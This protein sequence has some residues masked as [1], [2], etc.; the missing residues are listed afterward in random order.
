MK[1]QILACIGF[2][3]ASAITVEAYTG[4]PE[5]AP[6][7]IIVKLKDT[8]I[9]SAHSMQ[10]LKERHKIVETEVMDEKI[11][12]TGMAY[13]IRPKEQIVKLRSDSKLDAKRI[14][15]D[16]EKD[17]NVEYAEPNY[18][19]YLSHVPD[20]ALYSQQ[21]AHQNSNAED[22]WD[23]EQ[24]SGVVIA[25]IDTGV[26]YG[27]EDL[28][29]NM[30]GDCSNGC[31]D[32]T[33][34]DTVDIYT[35]WYE[36]EGYTLI[37]GEDYI[38]RDNDPFDYH[39]HGTHCAG[40][41]AGKADNSLGIAGACPGCKIM[42]IRASF[43]IEY[44]G[45]SYGCLEN[46]DV[47]A[48]IIYAT[49][50]GARV[51]SMS[52][53]GTASSQTIQNAVN[54][55]H[56]N[57]VTMLAAAGNFNTDSMVYPAALDNVI[58]VAA[59]AADNKK[60]SYSNYGSWVDI[61]AP[62]G[63]ITKDS[64]ILSTVP[65]YGIITHPSGYKPIQGTSMATPYAAGLAGLILSRK[66]GIVSED[67]REYMLLGSAETAE[68]SYAIGNRV[69]LNKTMHICSLS[70]SCYFADINYDDSISLGELMEHIGS[71]EENNIMVTGCWIEK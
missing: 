51:I 24:G 33:G 21:W 10:E 46:D 60:A 66:P 59:I 45:N 15:E 28:Q 67:V 34:Y 64:M 4:L 27:H 18:L 22:G 39:G 32:G 31:P 53:G 49:D 57:G 13:T 69:D 7:E 26:R 29:A 47:A 30:L 44:G 8:S 11:S 56:N 2:L 23:I 50:N 36:N 12:T 38:S 68:T 54:Y 70:G 6:G 5:Y 63:D 16:F 14:A 3:I 62:G 71:E 52:F 1:L 65:T 41:A 42:P 43:A 19:Y 35:S 9:L 17:P 20:D 40:I 55:A 61:A 48:A 25:I 37:S 58:G